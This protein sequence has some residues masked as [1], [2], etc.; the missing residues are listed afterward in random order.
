MLSTNAIERW[1]REQSQTHMADDSDTARRLA[2][3]IIW[4]QLVGAYI[5]CLSPIFT[6][7]FTFSTFGGVIVMAILFTYV[8]TLISPDLRVLENGL[9]RFFSKLL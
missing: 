6:D 8:V 2:K 9:A 5:G 1:H 4:Q 7:G 3:V